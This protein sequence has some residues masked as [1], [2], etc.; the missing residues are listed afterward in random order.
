MLANLNIFGCHA[1]VTVSKKKRSKFDVQ[2]VC[3]QFFGYSEH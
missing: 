1:Y 2:S 3:C